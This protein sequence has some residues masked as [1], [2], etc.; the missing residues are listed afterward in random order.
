MDKKQ[1]IRH[2]ALALTIPLL[3]QLDSAPF[4]RGDISLEEVFLCNEL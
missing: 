1:M 2:L 3:F 4:L